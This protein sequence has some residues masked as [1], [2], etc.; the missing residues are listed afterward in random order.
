MKPK[1]KP[2]LQDLRKEIEQ[3]KKQKERRLQ[4][5]T[6]MAERNNLLREINE[7]NAVKKSPNALKNF[8]KTFSKGLKL[9]G[10][11]L[12]R[13]MTRASKN[14][15]KNAPEFKEFSKTMTSQPKQ[16]RQTIKRVIRPQ[17]RMSPIFA[18]VPIKKTRI[19]KPLTKK[20]KSKKIKQKARRMVYNQ[21]EKE[22]PSWEMP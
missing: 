12:W 10:M 7:L 18:P 6:S 21:Q 4:I 5:A 22:M 2:S 9:T 19:I 3:L 11:A 20:K 8:G 13:G 15:N 16:K 14:L 17:P 1:T